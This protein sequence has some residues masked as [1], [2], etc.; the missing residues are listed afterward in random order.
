MWFKLLAIV[1][2]MALIGKAAIAL[3][4]HQKFYAARQRQYASALLPAKLLVGPILAIALACTAWYATLF[5]YRPWGWVITL[6]VTLLAAMSVEHLWR[7]R[8]HRERMLKVVSNPRVWQVDC[9][10]ML[11]GCGMVALGLTVY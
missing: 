1:L 6:F 2:G 8:R 5:Q 11:L 3:A 7:W 10:L 9:V 4:F